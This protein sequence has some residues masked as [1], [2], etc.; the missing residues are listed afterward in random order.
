MENFLFL[1]YIKKFDIFL[2]VDFNNKVISQLNL[3]SYINN[4]NYSC[5]LK[6]YNLIFKHLSLFGL[7][8]TN[9][10]KEFL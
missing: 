1:K 3:N 6:K 9:N 7:L 5:S 10:T 4:N 8:P 2:I